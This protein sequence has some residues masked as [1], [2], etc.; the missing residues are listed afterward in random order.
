MKNILSVKTSRFLV[1][2]LAF[3][4]IASLLIPLLVGCN[5]DTAQPPPQSKTP[6]ELE[7]EAE[8]ERL[9]LEEERRQEEARILE[10]RQ[11]REE[12]L[13]EELGPFFVPLPPLEQKENPRVKAKALYLTGHTIASPTRFQNL[14]ELVESTELNAMV[15]DVKND[16]GVM[17]Y[18][19]DIEIVKESGAN[20]SVPIKDI[21]S[22]MEELDRRGIYTIARIV[23]FKDPNL[24]EYR[25]DWAIQKKSGGIWREKRFAWVDPYQKNVWDYN[26]AIAKEAALLGFNEIQ[27]DYVRFP[28][29]ARKVDREA[30][31]P[32]NDGR[33]KDEAI[34]DFLAYA[35]EALEEYNIHLAADVFGVIATSWG[36]SDMIG[37]TWEK[38]SPLTEY[39]CP[40]IYPSHYGRGYFGYAVP[41]A[42]PEGVI[43]N[44]LTDAIKRN[45]P[46]Q[47]PAIIRPW[48]QS[49]TAT[50]VEGYIRYTHKQ[51][52]QQIDAALKLGID[53]FMIWNAGN[54]YQPASF[55]S[56]ADVEAHEAKIKAQREEKGHDVLG[57]S[58]AE[59]LKA[60][61]EAVR[62]RKW[63]ETYTLQS[64]GFTMDH[65]QHREWFTKWTAHL[66]NYTVKDTSETTGKTIITLD[67][68]M[69]IDK[70]VYDLSDVPFEV[71]IEN[72]IW[73]VKPGSEFLDLL[74][75]TPPETQD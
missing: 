17:S 30:F 60:Y 29:N 27:F 43:R 54:Y 56:A 50:W 72:Q 4:I 23:V 45:A 62:L 38:I 75:H 49:F 6:E 36:D 74:T 37:Q 1:F 28:E 12:A 18:Q 58:A 19:S 7:Q 66:R 14:I 64:T 41:D 13:R 3:A 57:R 39:I 9:R 44:A 73:R 65:Q 5:L 67:L 68:S 48:L 35:R 32:A 33:S 69:T 21:Q 26:I 70:E 11:Q 25:N 42:N 59:A 53:E 8:K 61:L 63:R 34:E 22:V 24:P 46:L 16:H 15:I 51:V 71:Y 40:M 55:L 52:R 47:E 2:I 20:R 10:E 31:Y